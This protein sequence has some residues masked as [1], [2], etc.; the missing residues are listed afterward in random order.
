MN[1]AAALA[2]QFHMNRSEAPKAAAGS[3][4][5]RRAARQTLVVKA[6]VTRDREGGPPL[7]ATL[8]DIS[9]LGIAFDVPERLEIG[10]RWPVS[11][12]CRP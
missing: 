10:S 4:E 9:L 8:A 5:R 6:L 2:D 7:L 12:A 3:K 1:R 11:S